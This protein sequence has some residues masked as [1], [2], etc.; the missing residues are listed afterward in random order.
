MRTLL[1]GVL[2][3]HGVA[4]IVGFVVPWRIV[5]SAEVPYRTTVLGVDVGPAGVRALG[6]VWLA[7]ACLFVVL[8]A[9]VFR[10]GGWWYREAFALVGLSLVLCLLGLPEARPGLLANAAIVALLVL[11]RIL[12]AY[13]DMHL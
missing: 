7:A 2:S 11:G 3:I 5:T 4:H 10:H 1:A 6:I 8:A 13:P 9:T 12:G